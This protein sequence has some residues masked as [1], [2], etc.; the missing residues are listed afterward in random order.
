M[1]QIKSPPQGSSLGEGQRDL[2]GPKNR[3][4]LIKDGYDLQVSVSDRGYV[5]HGFKREG[6]GKPENL[7]RREEGDISG[8]SPAS[9]RRL[10]RFIHDYREPD[11]W[12]NYGVTLTVPGP[13][14]T[15]KQSKDLWASFQKHMCRIKALIVWRA[16]VQQ[17]GAVHW[18]LLVSLHPSLN[19]HRVITERWWNCVEALGEVK[20]YTMK[21]GTVIEYASS[22][23]TLFGA[24][25]RCVDVEPQRESDSWFRYLCDHMSK[26]KQEQIGENIGRHWGIVGRKWAVPSIS[27]EVCELTYRE[28]FLLRRCLRRLSTPRVK[29]ESDPFGYSLGW[30]PKTSLYGRQDR[31]GHT[32]AVSRLLSWVKT[33]EG[34]G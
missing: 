30:A 32:Q 29:N 20:D 3:G 18:H 34:L 22:R 25:E 8:W 2:V 16:E 33:I 19:V 1:R 13:V 14:L 4:D 11:G 31:F 28:N 26:S 12:P 23:M 7:K 5:L 6:N 27:I 9:R 15:P 17:R 21:S 10:R 24:M